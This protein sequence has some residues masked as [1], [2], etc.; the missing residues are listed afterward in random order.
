[1]SEI[2][3]VLKHDAEAVEKRISQILQELSDGTDEIA[4]VLPQSMLYS[5]N[6]GGKRIRPAL[7]IEF[8]KMYGGDE[9]AAI[10]PAVAVELIHTYSLI[11]DDLPCMDNDD[12][13]RGRP[14]NHKVFG[15]ATALLAGDALLTLA[16]SVICESRYLSEHS[17]LEAISALAQFAGARGMIGG[18]QID[19]I[20]EKQRLSKEQHNKM[21]LMKTGALIKCSA[22]LGCITAGADE[23]QRAAAAVY[24]ENVGLAFQ[25]TDDLIDDGE[26]DEKTTYLTFMDKEQAKEY[27]KKLTRDAVSAI[28]GNAGSE[29]LSELA[30]F[31]AIRSV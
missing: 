19:L 29:V 1:M 30:Q 18:Q 8:C 27:A 12:I 20:G 25:V 23:K 4:R 31:L 3:N 11:H 16:F 10:D 22:L 24:A 6:G 7:T 14:T 13:R 17:K 15:Q 5:A 21:N 2:L 9:R 28:S 26:E